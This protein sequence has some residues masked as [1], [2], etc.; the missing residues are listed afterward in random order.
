MGIKI[1]LKFRA[2][3]VFIMVKKLLAVHLVFRNFGTDSI[4]FI[5]GNDLIL[6]QSLIHELTSKGKI[7]NKI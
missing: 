1:F 3:E 4:I 6:I 7:R 2:E 5:F